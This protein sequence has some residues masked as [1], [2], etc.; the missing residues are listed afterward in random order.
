MVLITGLKGV[1]RKRIANLLE[2]DLLAS[3]KFVYFLGI[4]SVIHGI[5]ADI[6]EETHEA[7]REEHMRRLAEVAHILLD[8]G[9]V[10]IVTAIEFSQHELEMLKTIINGYTITTV[11][12]GDT[13]SMDLEVDLEIPVNE[14]PM[15][16]VAEIKKLLREQGI[17]F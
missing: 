16:S 10:L 4:G 8:A 2:A 14:T 13:Q 5:D 7:S 12:V 6:R 11:W 17:V 9:V 15:Q 3:G 1:G